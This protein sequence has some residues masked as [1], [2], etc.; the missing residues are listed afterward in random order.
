MRKVLSLVLALS[1]VLGMFSF[2]FAATLSDI[3]GEYYEAAVEALVELGVVNGYTDGTYKANQVVTRAELAKM[4]VVSLGQDAAA[5][6]AKGSTQFTDVAADHWASGY[7][8]VAA[9]Y[10]VVVGYPDGT[11]DPEATVTYAEAVTMALRALGYKNVVEAAGTWPTNYIT[12]A[13]EL[14][15]LRDMKY[16]GAEDGAKRGN[17]AIL[18][19][20]ML[21]TEMWDIDSENQTNG[22]TYRKTEEPMLNIK[23]PDYEY[24]DEAEFVSYDVDGVKVTAKVTVTKKVNGVERT[25]DV[26]AELKSGDLLRLIPGMK[27]AY[28]YNSEDEVFLTLTNVDT[29]V[30]GRIDKDGKLNGKEYT[31]L[32]AEADDY[33]VVLVDGKKAVAYV[34]LPDDAK[35]IGQDE[36]LKKAQKTID[37]DTLVIIDGE[38]ATGEDLKEEDVYTKISGHGDDFYV[39][40]RERVEG[41]FESATYEKDADSERYYIEVDGDEYERTEEPHVYEYNEK[42]ED[43]DTVEFSDLNKKDNKYLDE[44]VELALNY[45]GDVINMY[46]GET[47]DSDDTDIRFYIVTGEHAWFESSKSG[48][49]YYVDLTDVNGDE[50]TQTLTSELGLGLLE[51]EMMQGGLYKALTAIYAEALEENDNDSEAA[52]EALRA[53]LLERVLV[54]ANLNDDDE[55]EL[56]KPA[57]IAKAYKI[58]TVTA[59]EG[60]EILDDDNYIAEDLKVTKSTKVITVTPVIDDDE[61]VGL[62]VEVSEGPD[63]LDGVTEAVYAVEVEENDDGEYVAKVKVNYVFVAQDAKSSELTFGVVE[64]FQTRKGIEYVVIDGTSYELNK[65]SVAAEVK[66]FVSFRASDDKEATIR[67]VLTAAGADYSKVVTKVEDELVYVNDELFVDTDTESAEEDYK[68]TTFVVLNVS[69]NKDDEVEFD[70]ADLL[71]EGIANASFKKGD[72]I[73]ELENDDVVVIIRG[74]K[75]DEKYEEGKL[76]EE[77]A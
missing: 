58:D 39:V 54:V 51:G 8:N 36:T 72:R 77:D 47:K 52:E 66:D 28:L 31:D 27:V 63:A 5:K 60:K 29:L 68:K 23:F 38:W 64:K 42:N 10:K 59:D 62:E 43:Y 2:A 22:M 56:A 71:G 57:D 18:L 46:F 73:V 1:M 30:E 3:D 34:T 33:V 41:T 25:E 44:D 15:L 76:V 65:E 49:K 16:D 7:I 12:K 35:E 45:L 53:A 6:I 48:V 19:W 69:V 70:D 55:L 17:V 75:A 26:E 61:V 9:Q 20:N 50:D 37:E 32:D 67:E 21:R 13:T 24:E 14:Q 4:L 11:F 74:L 40:A